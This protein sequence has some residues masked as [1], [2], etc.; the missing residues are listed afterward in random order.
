MRKQTKS[1]T[2]QRQARSREARTE[3]GGKQVSVFLEAKANAK[4]E[5]WVKAGYGIA[6]TINR[7][8]RSSR[9]PPK[10]KDVP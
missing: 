2:A 4:L 10:R 3:A 1:E 9:V 7:V 5:D 8:L 6:E